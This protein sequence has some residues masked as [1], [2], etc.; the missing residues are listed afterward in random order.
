MSPISNHSDGGDHR[1]KPQRL[2]ER[3]I[4]SARQHGED[5]DPDCEVGDLQEALRAAIT[6]LHVANALPAYADA[7]R[8]SLGKD[9]AEFEWL[10][11]DTP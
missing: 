7:L 4:A 5:S 6:C 11:A 3:I 9:Q 10:L 1:M 2:L 8:S